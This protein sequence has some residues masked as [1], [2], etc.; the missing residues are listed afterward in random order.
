MN[1][2]FPCGTTGVRELPL[3][4]FSSDLVYLVRVECLQMI[5]PMVIDGVDGYAI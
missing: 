4:L 2:R 1:L 3:R 5:K